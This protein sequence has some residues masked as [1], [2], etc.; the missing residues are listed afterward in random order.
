MS[1]FSPI[2]NILHEL[3][4]FSINVSPNTGI[5]IV[6][7]YVISFN[8]CSQLCLKKDLSFVYKSSIY[9]LYLF[10]EFDLDILKI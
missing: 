1:C 8:Y 5:E 6:K 2:W 7:D 9:S 4:F 10:V 3:A